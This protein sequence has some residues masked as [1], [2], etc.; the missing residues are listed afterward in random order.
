MLPPPSPSLDLSVILEHRGRG[1]AG[2][3]G[4]GGPGPARRASGGEAARHCWSP[5]GRLGA[6]GVGAEHR[7]RP[8]P[9]PPRPQAPPTRWPP[10]EEPLRRAHALSPGS[11][12]TSGGPAPP[13]P[14]PRA[15]GPPL[16]SRATREGSL[17]SGKR[18]HE[19]LSAAPR[20]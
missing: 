13:R 7:A 3:R 1:D 12:G 15:S 16:L 17:R 6:S 20:M 4:C 5:P 2:T 8:R 19:P 18:G 9:A 11:D 14:N 10:R